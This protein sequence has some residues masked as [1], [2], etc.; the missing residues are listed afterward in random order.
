MDYD[1]L[2]NVILN[3]GLGTTAIVAMHWAAATLIFDHSASLH[4]VVDSAFFWVSVA[5]PIAWALRYSADHRF[6]VEHPLLLSGAFLSGLVYFVATMLIIIKGHV[7]YGVLSLYDVWDWL[8]IL[9]WVSGR[10][11][12]VMAV[13]VV[14]MIMINAV[15]R[16]IH[17]RLR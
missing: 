2:R 17:D 9:S 10:S 3:T 11:L 14:G 13:S 8:N 15:Y 5:F 12:V 6:P 4:A 7:L 1:F 16:L